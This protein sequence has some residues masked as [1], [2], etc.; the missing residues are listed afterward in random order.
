M[1]NGDTNE[2]LDGILWGQECWLKYNGN[3]HFIQGWTT[4]DGKYHLVHEFYEIHGDPANWTY[5]ANRNWE[6]V[7]EDNEICVKA[8]LEAP[9]WDGKKFWQAES[10][11]EWMENPL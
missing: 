3:V 11:I 10:E 4:D 9:I 1:I 2:F 7:D 8:F 6:A 5:D